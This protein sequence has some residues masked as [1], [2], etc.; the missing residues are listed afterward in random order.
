MLE[1]L[2]KIFS[3]CKKLTSLTLYDQVL[4]DEEEIQ[5]QIVDIFPSL[6][7]VCIQVFYSIF[8]DEKLAEMSLAAELEKKNRF[9]E[10]FKNY[11]TARF[12]NLTHAIQVDDKSVE[13]TYI[14]FESRPAKC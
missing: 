8:D 5:S 9:I 7:H 11:L 3:K 10:D 14:E 1:L 6:T 2:K 13:D 4:I 12:P